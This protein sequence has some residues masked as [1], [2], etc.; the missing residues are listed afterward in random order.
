[1][2]GIKTIKTNCF[3]LLQIFLKTEELT[4]ANDTPEQ[5]GDRI[6]DPLREASR[7]IQERLLR[8]AEQP[9]NSNS[10]PTGERNLGPVGRQGENL[11]ILALT[12]GQSAATLIAE[13]QGDTQRILNRTLA[14]PDGGRVQGGVFRTVDRLITETGLA[15]Q[16]W[17]A[18]PTA[19]N[20]AL[21]RVG[22]DIVLVNRN[23]GDVIF[24]DATS[25]DKTGDGRSRLVESGIVQAERNWFDPNG[26]LDTENKEARDFRSSLAQR[27]ERMTRPE[28]QGGS[29]RLNLSE[30]RLPGF[31]ST[32]A[33]SRE[34]SEFRSSL[35]Q[36]ARRATPERASYIREFINRQVNVG[37]NFAVRQTSAASGANQELLREVGRTANNVVFNQVIASLRPEQDRPTAIPDGRPTFRT[38]AEMSEI[39]FTPPGRGQMTGGSPQEAIGNAVNYWLL[40]RENS[41]PG[42]QRLAELEQRLERRNRA[43][44]ISTDQFLENLESNKRVLTSGGLGLQRPVYRDLFNRLNSYSPEQITAISGSAAQDDTRQPPRRAANLGNLRPE[45]MVAIEGL[46]ANENRLMQEAHQRL[47]TS[48]NPEARRIVGFLERNMQEARAGRPIT[49]QAIET[50][51]RIA[52]RMEGGSGRAA[53]AAGIGLM[54]P[55]LLGLG[56]GSESVGF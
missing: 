19:K 47:S 48:Q 45:A 55:E 42:R 1:V 21:D 16:G 35:E 26:N 33:T 53:A 32:V 51:R 3:D 41:E 38:N 36:A 8:D 30:I 29:P 27:L 10:R 52:R 6:P 11:P 50:M 2:V 49:D 17:V 14:D 12:D 18:L 20:S 7:R 43:S 13:R 23:S 31:E 54:L 24:M 44:A 46:N 9:A 56:A 15:N 5:A 28:N 39:I 4:M 37:E 25:R 22:A 40:A 34:V